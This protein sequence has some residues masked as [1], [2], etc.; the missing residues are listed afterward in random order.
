MRLRDRWLPTPRPLAMFHRLRAG[1]LPAEGYLLTEKVPDAVGLPEAVRAC[2]DAASCVPGRRGW[3]ACCGR[4]T[5]A[6]CRTA[7]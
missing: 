6:A 2:R 5:T 1:G 3:P 7:T 4:C